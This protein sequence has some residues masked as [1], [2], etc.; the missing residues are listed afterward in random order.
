MIETNSPSE[1]QAAILRILHILLAGELDVEPASIKPEADLMDDL[2]FDSVDLFNLAV[3]LG[4]TFDLE[5]DA[6]HLCEFRTLGDTAK[7]VEQ[8]LLTSAQVA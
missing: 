1:T 2:Y 4:D 8:L 3:L 6:G 5:I 7:G